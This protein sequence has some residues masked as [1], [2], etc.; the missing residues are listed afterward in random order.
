MG[1]RHSAPRLF[2]STSVN[3]TAISA[4]AARRRSISPC[5]AANSTSRCLSRRPGRDRA[6]ASS[7]PCPAT[8]RSFA[9]LDRSTR[10]RSA[11]SP[12]VVSPRT[13][14][15][16][17][18]YFSCGARNRF[19]FMPCPVL[20]RTP[21]CSVENPPMLAETNHNQR[22]EVSPN[23]DLPALR[24]VAMAP[25]SLPSSGASN[26]PSA[27]HSAP[28]LSA[29]SPPTWPV[30]LGLHPKFVAEGCTAAAVLRT[31]GG[32]PADDVM[33]CA[34]RAV[35]GVVSLMLSGLSGAVCGPK[36][37]RRAEQ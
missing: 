8:S 17:I 5:A 15:I 24:S 2:S 20:N 35:L 18:S 34:R 3:R 31:A 29:R 1:L 12:T 26:K 28:R 22:H 23:T 4:N 37:K 21:Q 36:W 32:G 27:I 7:A 11:A 6:S 16:Q 33:V 30:G 13:N 25:F 14:C 9:I 10:A 19:L